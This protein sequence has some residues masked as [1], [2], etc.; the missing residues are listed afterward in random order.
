MK[1]QDKTAYI[2]YR[3]EKAK[4]AQRDALVLFNLGSYGASVNRLYYSAFYGVSALM[5]KHNIET[6]THNGIKIAF[7][8]NFVKS[9]IIGIEYGKLFNQLF[10][11][12]H[13]GDYNDF[14]D[15]KKEDVEPL[16]TKTTEFIGVI[17][18]LLNKI[19]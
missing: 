1:P 8:S 18:S 2:I 13:K 3:L 7:N 19:E 14:F 5:L 6:K 17:E 15:F 10:E 9:E 16:L 12:R 11:L 4:D